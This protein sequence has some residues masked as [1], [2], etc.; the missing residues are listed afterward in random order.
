MLVVSL[1]NTAYQYLCEV[2]S[3]YISKSILTKE[4]ILKKNN[5]LSNFLY[6]SILS[7]EF[8]S[9]KWAIIKRRRNIH[10]FILFAV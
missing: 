6:K 7:T 10:K 9:N 1:L 5:K 3:E 8:R 4:L 2:S